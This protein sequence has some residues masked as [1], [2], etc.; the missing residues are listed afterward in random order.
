MKKNSFSATIQSA[1]GG[2]AYVLFPFDVVECFGVKGRIPVK[3]TIDGA[4]YTGSM[5]KY[6]HPQHMLLILKSIREQIGKH[7]GD[8]VSVVIWRDEIQRT[9]DIPPLF[10][11]LLKKEKLLQQ[12]EKLSYT[13]RKEYIAWMT[14]AKKEETRIARMTKAIEMLRQNLKTPH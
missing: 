14:N 9:I 5:V 6:G 2:G 3:A 7:P 10:E 4:P 8:E 13:H 1:G 11:Q 12:F